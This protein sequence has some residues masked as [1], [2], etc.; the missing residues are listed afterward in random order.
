MRDI[1]VHADNFTACTTSMEY[2][3]RLAASFE[4][5]ITGVYVCPSPIGAMAPYDAPQ[6]VSVVVEEIRELEE[7]AAAG[8]DMFVSRAK[9]LAVAK[10]LW[11]VAEGNTPEVLAHLGNW[12]DVVV[13][14]RDPGTNFSTA[15]MLGSAVLGSHMPCIIVPPGCTKPRFDCVV[16]AWNGSP[17]AIRAIH[18]ARPIL[19]RAGRIVVLAGEPREHFSE[20]GWKPEFDLAAYL[21]YHGFAFEERGLQTSADEA[22]RALLAAASA[23]SADL[24][25]MGAY[26]R[27]RFSE[28]IFGGATRHVL[29]EATM[30]V[31]MR[32]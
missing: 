6:L 31:F 19:A 26:G 20:I 15:A 27:T 22:G 21:D 9:E 16:L 24:L 2:A 29:T 5:R 30:P 3:M 32:H 14:G 23:C 17:E 7:D 1:L 10:A 8:R 12:H 28:W 25:V 4:G 13:L 11:Q 18:A